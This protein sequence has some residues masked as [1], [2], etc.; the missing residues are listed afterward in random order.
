MQI[1]TLSTQQSEDGA[2]RYESDS[3]REITQAEKDD[4]IEI[5]D[6]AFP[7]EDVRRYGVCG[8]EDD[9]AVL[10]AALRVNDRVRIPQ[11][12]R[13][14]VKDVIIASSGKRIEGPGTLVGISG[15]TF[16]FRIE[17]GGQ[18]FELN[19]V[20]IDTAGVTYGIHSSADETRVRNVRFSGNTGNYIRL[21]GDYGTI[22]NCEH[23]AGYNQISSFVVNGESPRV[24]RCR[25]NDHRGFGI[26]AIFAR[27]VVIEH[28]QIVCTRYSDMQTAT[29]GQT[30][31][32]VNLTALN[33]ERF[34]VTR[35]GVQVGFDYSGTGP[36]YTITLDDAASLS[37]S[38]TAYGWR[39]AE[40]IQINSEV[41]GATIDSC[42]CDGSGDSNIVVVADYHNGVDTAGVGVDLDD[43]PSNV[44]IKGC[45]LSKALA[46]S[47][48]VH[49]SVSATIST[50]TCTEFGHGYDPNQTGYAAI[51]VNGAIN[52]NV[53]ANTLHGAEART[54]YG[55][56][57]WSGISASDDFD[58]RRPRLWKKYTKNTFVG[59]FTRN[60]FVAANFTDAETRYGISIADIEWM[61]YP[62]ASLQDLI[63]AAQTEQAGRPNNSGYW[64]NSIISGTTPCTRDTG[65][66]IAGTASARSTTGDEWEA[67]PVA[68][69][70]L[71]NSLVRISFSAKNSSA[72]KGQLQIKHDRGGVGGGY[73]TTVMKVQ[74][75]DWE[76]HAIVIAI[77]NIANPLLLRFIGPP[78]SGN[79]YFQL[80]RIQYA[81]PDLV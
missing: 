6:I 17:A 28:S 62:G 53:S 47:I 59:D 22:D 44:S 80:P 66:T 76:E 15:S 61:E 32:T 40:N 38:V 34:A 73:V 63:D 71:A 81:K 16:L 33:I 68:Y 41:I 74:S 31:F 72:N 5:F 60:Y 69:P 2:A 43:Y 46:N 20:A 29:A 58:F 13:M 78:T 79:V 8:T 55:I 42:T 56:A 65:V 36:T 49:H 77:G 24:S 1:P 3:F 75:A 21:E 50:N 25:L 67:K 54:Q 70:L 51:N 7:P 30:V 9:T 14:A 23:A 35:N 48:A 4:G 37:D 10:L 64:I 45:I 27:N 19:N 12:I 52:A 18:D 57:G 39:G 11:S 26:Q